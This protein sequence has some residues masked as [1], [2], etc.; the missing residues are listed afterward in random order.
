MNHKDAASV[1]GINGEVNAEIL[2][3]AYKRAAMKF[4][5]D[6]G[7]SLEMMQAVNA[8]REVLKNYVGTV[9]CEEGYDEALN[10]AINAV[11]NLDGIEIEV[12]GAWIWVSGNTRPHKDAIK[13]ADYFWASK[14]MM[15]Y[16]RPTEWKGGRG[17]QSM[18]QIRETHGSVK[19]KTVAQARVT[20]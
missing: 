3:A 9:E 14:K 18:D 12:C 2:S 19:I 8:A 6:R 11:I 1:L 15:W 7:G 20:A 5:P 16:Y 10:D 13:G 17:T 4:H